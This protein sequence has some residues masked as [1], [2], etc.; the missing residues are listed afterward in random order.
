[1]FS[2]V[3]P[4]RNGAATIATQLDAL[5]LQATAG[6]SWE[7]VV[8]DN[9]STDATLDVVAGYSDRLPIRVVDAP[10]RANLAYARNV[11]VASAGGDKIAFCDADDVVGDGWLAAVDAALDEHPIVG[12]RFEWDLLNEPGDLIGR[13]RFQAAGLEQFFGLPVVSGAMAVQRSLWTA[14]GGNN[15]AWSF[16]GEDYEFCLRAARLTGAVAHFEPNAVYHVRMRSTARSSFRQARRY[17]RAHVALFKEFVDDRPSPRQRA[18][19]GVRGWWWVVLRLP[20]AAADR[21]RRPLVARRLGMRV[22]R[23]SESL[24]SRTFLP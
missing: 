17:G 22:G 13:H 20:L 23:L 6:L 19:D 8:V 12:Y 7:V 18:V 21:S 3:L 14:L 11:G 1:M 15:E 5:T 9:G 24:R 2:V 16:T 10:L 4:V